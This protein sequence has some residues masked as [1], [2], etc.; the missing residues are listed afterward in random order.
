MRSQCASKTN[1]LKE[2]I[3][4]ALRRFMKRILLKACKLL[5]NSQILTPGNVQGC[6]FS[7]H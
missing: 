5:I 2:E 6:Q 7:T 4:S 1:L 3:A